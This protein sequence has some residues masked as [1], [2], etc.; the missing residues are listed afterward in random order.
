ME[1]K[2]TKKDTYLVMFKEYPDILKKW[3]TQ[4]NMM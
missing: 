1:R 4:K 2:I 3:Q